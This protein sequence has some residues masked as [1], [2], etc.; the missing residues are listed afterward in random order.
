MGIWIKLGIRPQYT[1]FMMFEKRSSKA[2]TSVTYEM[3]KM[4]YFA[5][6]IEKIL[7]SK[8]NSNRNLKK[9]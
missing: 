5:G 3:L 6:K 9:N 4:C 1:K 2:C 8:S 7:D